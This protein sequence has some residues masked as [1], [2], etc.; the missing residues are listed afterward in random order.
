MT[1]SS[2]RRIHTIGH[3]TR[4]A[5]EFVSLLLEHHIAT[6]ADVRRFPFS[7][8]YPHFNGTELAKELEKEGIGYEHVP[9]IGGRRSSHADSPN[10][11]WRNDSFRAYADYMA[12]PEFHAGIDRLLALQQ[13]VAIMCAEAVPWRCHRNLISDEL[14]RRGYEV[15]HI[16]GVGS[17]R[18]HTLNANAVD[19]GTHLVYPA[20]GQTK[21]F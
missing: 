21:L 5:A 6:L 3:S 17:T 15:V 2:R 8:R 20:G 4:T 18:V 12:T 10:T 14:T 1:G 16:L 7:R 11:A 9:E 19:T 13:P